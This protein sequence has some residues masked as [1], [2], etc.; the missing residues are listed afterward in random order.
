MGSVLLVSSCAGPGHSLCCAA[1]HSCFVAVPG[2]RGQLL[3]SAGPL[4]SITNTH[5]CC[6][7]VSLPGHMAAVVL[8]AV[9]P[10][11]PSAHTHLSPPLSLPLTAGT[12]SPGGSNHP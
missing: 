6:A 7:A 11:S 1:P 10:C 12:T 8:L 2:H 3:S 9:H 4:L 5:T